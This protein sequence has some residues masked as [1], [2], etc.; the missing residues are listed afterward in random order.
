MNRLEV[1]VKLSVPVF[2]YAA[3]DQYGDDNDNN[4]EYSDTD[5]NCD[6]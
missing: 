1:F 5:S 6:V 3:V 4:T 2:H